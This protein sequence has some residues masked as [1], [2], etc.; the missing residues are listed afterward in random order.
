MNRKRLRDLIRRQTEQVYIIAHGTS[1]LLALQT[2]LDHPRRI[3]AMVL[4]APRSHYTSCPFFSA[5]QR[6]PW[7]MAPLYLLMRDP[8]GEVGDPFSRMWRRLR[9]IGPRVIG[10]YMKDLK[11]ID[12]RNRLSEVQNRICLISG[13]RDSVND[14]EEAVRMNEALPNSYLVRYGNMGHSPHLE[15]PDIINHIIHDFLKKSE[16]VLGRSIEQ[17][18]GFFKSLFKKPEKSDEEP[19][20]IEGPGLPFPP[21]PDES[22]HETNQDKQ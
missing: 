7:I 14:P 8:L 6:F 16:S 21:L 1:T 18:R 9:V 22:A 4:I 2:A 12:L 13:D 19:G 17:I 20:A 5:G 3:K 11:G 10:R 15:E